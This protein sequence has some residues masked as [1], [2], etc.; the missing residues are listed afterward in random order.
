[1]SG[2]AKAAIA[3]TAAKAKQLFEVKGG[4]DRFALLFTMQVLLP[5]AS[6][7]EVLHPQPG[8]DPEGRMYLLD[9]WRKQSASVVL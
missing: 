2:D 7:A 5:K 1:M 4:P 6:A 8:L 9:R 3:E